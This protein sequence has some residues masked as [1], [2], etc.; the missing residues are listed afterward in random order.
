MQ[1]YSKTYIIPIAFKILRFDCNI[2]TYNPETKQD[3]VFL[4]TGIFGRKAFTVV[5]KSPS[6]LW[7]LVKIT[8]DRATAE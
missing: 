8:A 5:S 2:I 7:L 6:I 1:C 3:F 4:S